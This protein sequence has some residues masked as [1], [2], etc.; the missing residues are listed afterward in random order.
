MLEHQVTAHTPGTFEIE[1]HYYPRVLNAQI[2]PMVRFFL[3]MSNERIA[4]RYCHLNPDTDYE[5]VINILN[6]KPKHFRWGGADLFQTTTDAGVRRTVVIETNSS[7]SG[8]KSMPLLYED[9]E[10]R[11]YRKLLENAFLP[12]LKRRSTPEGVLAVLHDKNPMETTGYAAVLADITGET[13]YHVP[14]FVD[15]T[16]PP[17]RFTEDGVLEIRMEDDTWRT[18]RG[19]LKYVTQ[20]PWSRI[21]PITRTVIFNP[22]LC[23]LAGGRNKLLAAKAYDLYNA[24]LLSKG[25]QIHAPETIWDVSHNEIPLWF[26]RMGGYAVVKNPYSNAGQG[27][28]T[29][30]SQQE[31][32]AFMGLEHRYDRFI[33]QALIGNR[34]WSSRSRNGQ[35]YHLGTLPNRKNE[36]FVIDFRFMIGAGPNGCYPVAIYARR[37]RS[38]LVKDL[39]GSQSS[40]DMLG[41]NLSVKRSD[42]GWDTESQRLMLMDSRDFNKLG[43][44]LDDLVES[45]I[46]SVLSV[47]AID[48]MSAQLLTQKG[49]FRRRLFK[50]LNPD[51]ALVEEIC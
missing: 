41:T 15:D 32:E 30:T 7:P 8:Q 31:L 20:R 43:I 26:A 3:E 12:Q 11:G 17:A 25:L 9:Q 19:A 29:L 48:R 46:Q 14:F 28:W 24:D 39:E 42:G 22:V 6:S 35:L 34:N 21:P 44:G 13:V 51:P 38:P 18:V 27:V 16:D 49:R 2:H 10:Q 45:Y 50:S 33:V 1:K 23:C 5:T 36:L 40:W 37:A 4:K 47:I